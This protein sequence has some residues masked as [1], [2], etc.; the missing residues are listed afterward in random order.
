MT[1]IGRKKVAFVPVYRPHA[2]PP[3]QIPADWHNDILRR[4]L[5]D[6]DSRT[7]RD[8]SLRAYIRAAS[9]GVADL[10]AVVLSMQTVDAQDVPA[11][12]LEG[13]LG[14]TLRDQGFDAAAI[15]MLGGPGA[16]TNAGFWSRFVMAE[17][18]GVWAM[19]LIHGLTGFGDLYPFGGDMGGVRR[20]GLFL[21]HA[22]VGLHEGGHRLA[23]SERDR[24]PERPLGAARA[25]LGR[26]H[27]TA[28]VRPLG[29]PCGSAAS[30]PYLMVE[31]RQRVDQ[32]DA[33]IPS[34]GSD[35]LS[36]CRR[37]IRWATLRTARLRLTC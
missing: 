15:V 29:R 5:F 8:R 32:F 9:S 16:G 11:N 4:V 6:P 33:G 2:L 34:E 25:A 1:W 26:P 37:P 10:D 13:Q 14:S 35:R 19:E 20:D 28:A 17:G 31:A 22:P 21:R 23:R 24:R 27:P 12:A 30:V 3:D 7:G 18:V 36:A